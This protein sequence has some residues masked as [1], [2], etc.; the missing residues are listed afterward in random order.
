MQKWLNVT[1]R[2]S[3]YSIDSDYEEKNDSKFKNE[4]DLSI[5]SKGRLIYL[6]ENVCLMFLR[7]F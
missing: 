5:I 1:L 7:T 4:G 6:K 3:N 2:D